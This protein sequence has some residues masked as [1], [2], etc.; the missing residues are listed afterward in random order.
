MKRKKQRF[1]VAVGTSAILWML[2][3]I[4]VMGSQAWTPGANGNWIRVYPPPFEIMMLTIFAMLVTIWLWTWYSRDRVR[5]ML[6][7]LD[8]DE[9]EHLTRLLTLEGSQDDGEVNRKRKRQVPQDEDWSDY[10]Y[11]DSSGAQSGGVRS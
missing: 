8:A 7:T 4:R 1:V 6:T 11:D 3:L 9:R 5:H 2:V 10:R